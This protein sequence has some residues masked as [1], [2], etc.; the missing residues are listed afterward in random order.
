MNFT[1][2]REAVNFTTNYGSGDQ[3]LNTTYLTTDPSEYALGDNIVYND[4]D[5]REFT[6]VIN[7]RLEDRGK[8]LRVEGLKCLTGVCETTVVEEVETEDTKR[9]WSD[10]TN[11]PDETLPVD[12]DDVIIEP[13][14]DMILDI[15]E[16]PILNSLEINGILTFNDTDYDITLNSHRVY[17]RA[18][19]LHIGNETHPYSNV[20]TI[21][22]HGE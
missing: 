14:W 12:G 15:P 13:G 11:W 19:E 1:D 10:A 3:I 18:G 9:Y 7:N 6:F 8:Q 16:T 2:V 22:L 21:V 20:A 17:V 4:T 5:T